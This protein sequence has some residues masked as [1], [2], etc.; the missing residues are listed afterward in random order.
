MK[1]VRIRYHIGESAT[2]I[3]E[4]YCWNTNV[5]TFTDRDGTEVFIPFYDVIFIEIKDIV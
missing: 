3:T 4:K 1:K 2:W 5:I